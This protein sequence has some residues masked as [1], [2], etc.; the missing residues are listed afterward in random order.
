MGLMALHGQRKVLDTG[1]AV[2]GG[3]KGASGV[4]SFC[5]AV[6]VFGLASQLGSAFVF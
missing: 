2:A 4:S 6:C 5:S 3:G 1:A